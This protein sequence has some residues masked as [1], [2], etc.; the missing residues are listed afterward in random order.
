MNSTMMQ[1]FLYLSCYMHEIVLSRRRNMHR[2]DDFGLR[3]L[4]DMKLMQVE[5]ALDLE[6]Q[7]TNFAER[8]V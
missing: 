4:P 7:F 1:R 6:N 3:Q 8:D 2:S 5:D